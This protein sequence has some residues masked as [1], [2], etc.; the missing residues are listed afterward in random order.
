MKKIIKNKV[1]DTDKAVLTATFSNSDDYSDFSH[2][3]ESLYRKKI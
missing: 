1:Y 3:E 2:F